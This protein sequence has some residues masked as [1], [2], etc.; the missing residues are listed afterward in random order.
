MLLWCLCKGLCSKGSNEFGYF[1]GSRIL[2]GLYN[3]PVFQ[4]DMSA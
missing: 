4:K 1:L 3:K 2:L